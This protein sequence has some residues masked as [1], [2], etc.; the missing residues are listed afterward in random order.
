[1]EESKETRLV[2]LKHRKERVL[3]IHLPSV[4]FLSCHHV[5]QTKAAINKNKQD[6]R[7][8]YDNKA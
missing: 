6:E 8:D 5:L 2:A 1:M 3:R 4:S 7:E